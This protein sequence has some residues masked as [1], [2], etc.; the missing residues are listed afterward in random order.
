[1]PLADPYTEA[2]ESTE[3][4]LVPPIGITDFNEIRTDNFYF[5]DKTCL[6]AK[7]LKSKA[8]AILFTRPRRFGKTLNTSMI[9]YFFDCNPVNGKTPAENRR[10]FDGL[11]ICQDAEAMNEQGKYPV[12]FMSMKDMKFTAWEKF[13]GCIK[14]AIREQADQ[15]CYLKESSK[16]SETE[17][18]QV[19]ELLSSNISDE[20]CSQSLRLLSRLL[21]KHHGVPAIL[22][23]DEYDAPIQEAYAQGYYNE[24]ITFMRS[25]LGA[26]LKDNPAL[27]FACLTGVM[28]VAKESI[29]SGL[30]NLTVDTVLSKKFADCFGFTQ[31]E[32]D[33]MAKYLG[34]ENKLPEIKAWYDGY[35]FGDKE[36]YNPWSV[37][38]YFN[39]DNEAKAY[40]VSTSSNG[41]VT[42][43]LQKA[44]T[45]AREQLL[46]LMDGK[47]VKAKVETSVSY[48]ELNSSG[49][50]IFSFL[51]MTGYL[52]PVQ[53]LGRSEYTLTIP[54]YEIN[55]IYPREILGMLSNELNFN[56]IEQLFEYMMDGDDYH[57]QE[58]ISRYYSACVSY[59]DT[60][61]LFCQGFMLGLAAALIPYYFVKSN[62]EAGNG[63]V[64]IILT[65]RPETK[66]YKWRKFPG[67]VIELKYVKFKKGSK[68]RDSFKRLKEQAQKA[69]AQITE[70][71]Y[72]AELTNA[73]ITPVLQYGLAFGH[74]ATAVASASVDHEPQVAKSH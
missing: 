50:S 66:D 32:V 22:L 15:F 39:H 33:D 60:G 27:K 4:K 57:F 55:E 70:N 73:G 38:N 37:L 5:V 9:Q 47:P 64:D 24:M 16:L 71:N 51:L 43:V 14:Y 30:N 12:I 63:R 19:A 42:E 72:T 20:A 1:M 53:D 45:A 2:M 56:G 36:I 11:S 26:G 65:P 34:H 68:T 40:W 18:A 59:Y 21:Q 48:R 62:L 61:E 41:V 28:R 25:F 46:G 54:N 23:I 52:K 17:R 35:L 74:K 8:K 29:F 69:L 13:L 31:Q 3:E 44:D 6:I 49:N 58:Q 10:L 7:L 67:I